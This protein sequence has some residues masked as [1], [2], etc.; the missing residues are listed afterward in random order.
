[1]VAFHKGVSEQQIRAYV[2]SQLP[3]TVSETTASR[4]AKAKVPTN[5]QPDAF[6]SFVAQNPQLAEVAKVPVNL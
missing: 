3:Q 2:R 4:H 6:L 5:V 1:M